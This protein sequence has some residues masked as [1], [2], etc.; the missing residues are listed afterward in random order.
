MDDSKLDV[1]E[2]EVLRRL[3][4]G[5]VTLHIRVLY[6]VCALMSVA[7]LVS[8]ILYRDELRSLKE[9][10][11]TDLVELRREHEGLLLEGMKFRVAMDRVNRTRRGRRHP[12]A[13]ASDSASVMSRLK[14]MVADAA[15]DGEK[16]DGQEEAD[17]TDEEGEGQHTTDETYDYTTDDYGSGVTTSG[18]NEASF[19]I[20]SDSR[21]PVGLS[22]RSFVHS[23][24]FKFK[25]PFIEI[26]TT[27]EHL[28]FGDRIR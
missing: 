4:R 10:L 6:A 16:K 3:S 15:S 8:H 2:T 11:L 17:D 27:S 13:R 9:T 25:M 1:E 21:L 5:H 26:P 22:I 19:W 24:K 12:G 18:I 23:F 7:A 14:R 28:K 20:S